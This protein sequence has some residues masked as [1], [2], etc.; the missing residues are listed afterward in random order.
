MGV[1][2]VTSRLEAAKEWT[3]ARHEA[4]V[5]DDTHRA[6]DPMARFVKRRKW[7]KQ[8]YRG[9]RVPN[10][11]GIAPDYRWDGTD[12]SNGFEVRVLTKQSGQGA[13]REAR[14]LYSVED[15]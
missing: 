4:E 9:R 6:G 2:G 1:W 7:G 8:E 3:L 12:R 10:R 11:W 13:L 15:L 14:H 5:P